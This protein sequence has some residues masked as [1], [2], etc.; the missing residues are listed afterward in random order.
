MN[1][2]NNKKL[3]LDKKFLEIATKT[4]S[5]QPI[6]RDGWYIKLSTYENTNFLLTF[7]S[8][9]TGQCILR[10]FNNE[11]SAIMF[12]NMV[13]MLDSEQEYEF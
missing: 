13:T 2:R 5:W 11:D 7:I 12:I 9:H 1:Q 4:Q 10:Y 3:L 6:F 8:K